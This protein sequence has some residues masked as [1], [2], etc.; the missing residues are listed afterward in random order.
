MIAAVR[1]AQIYS[2]LADEQVRGAVQ[3]TI[4]AVAGQYYEVLL[5]RHLYA[6]NQDAVKSAERHLADVKQKR[7]GGLASEFDVLRAEVD[8][9]SFKAEMIQQRNRVHLAR[10]RLLRT[11]GVSQ[12]SEVALSDELTYRPMKPILQEAMRVAHGNRPDLYQAELGVRFQDEAVRIVG[13]QYWPR[14]DAVFTQTWARPDPHSSTEDE[15]GD[16]WTVGAVL[17]WPLFDGFRRR[18]RLIE[19]RARLEQSHIR[20]LDAQERAQLEIQQAIL[21]L[22]DAEEFV[23]SQRLNLQRAGEALRLA[24]VGYRQGV[25]T[26]V[27]VIDAR[28]ALT[29]AKGLHYQ[30]VY[31]HVISRLALQR[32]MGILGPR[33]GDAPATRE[34]SAQPGR[35]EEFE[36]REEKKGEGHKATGTPAVGLGE[37]RGGTP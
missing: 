5:A 22:R 28:A 29:R 17:E 37:H 12:E 2:A 30:A 16:A 26:E 19:E 21:S 24:E 36:L 34:G 6:V 35:I 7:K 25:N 23:E 9:S 33:A 1:T 11:M 18:G 20:L 32:A 13:S 27:E 10:A 14:V 15:W 31:S 4:H 3:G 8:V